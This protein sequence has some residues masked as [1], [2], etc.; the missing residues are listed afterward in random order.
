[1]VRYVYL[2]LFLQGHSSVLSNY[3]IYYVLL[4]GYTASLDIRVTLSFNLMLR[5]AF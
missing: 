1:M 2:L 3:F 5:F 4:Y